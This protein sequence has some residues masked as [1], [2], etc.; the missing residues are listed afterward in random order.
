MAQT[1][2]P[3]RESTVV[4]KERATFKALLAKN[5]N[6]FG[7]LEQVAWKPV[8][9]IVAD[10]GHEQLTCVG[11]NPR[12]SFLEATIAVKRPTG[13]A[14]DLCHA[15]STEYVRFFLDYGSGWEDAGLTGVQVH[16]IPNHP[17]CA[18]RPDKP[19]TYVASL[20]IDPRRDCC[21]HPVLPRVRAI[22]SWQWVPPAG[23]ANVNWK[24]VWG[25]VLDCDVQIAPGPWTIHCLFDQVHVKVP[26]IFEQVQEQPIPLPDPP[27][28]ELAELAELYAPEKQA[29]SAAGSAKLAVAPHRYGLSALHP[30][31]APEGGFD[32]TLLSSSAASFEAIDV[33]LEQAL[34][35]LEKTN[36]D[37][38]YEQLECVGLDETM[39]ERLVATFRIKR[40]TG[41]SGSLCR[42]GSR[43]YVAFWA[44]WDDKCEWTYLGTTQVNVH[45]LEHQIP[46]EGLC[47]SAIL[48]VDLTHRRRGCKEPKIGRV[49]AV[50]SWQVPP[51]TTDP[52]KLEYWGN[53]LDAHVQI[54]P[55]DEIPPGKVLAKIRNLGGIAVEDVAT[56]GNGLTLAADIRFAHFP[57]KTAD[58]WSLQRQCPFGGTVEIEGNFFP[59][60]WY[61][62]KVRRA[63]DPPTSFTALGNSF[64]LE[65]AWSPGY[66]T[67]TSVGG[68]F[69]YADPLMYFTRTLAEW[70]TSEDGLW[71]VQLDIATAPSEASI[72][73]SSKWYSILIDNTGPVGPPALLPTMDIHIA[74]GG[75]CKD[76]DEGATIEGTFIA[77]DAHFGHWA[78]STEPNTAATPSNPPQ[79]SPF[80][81]GT[82]PAPWPAGHGWALNTASPVK[83]KPCGYV[84]R[85]DVSDR[86]IV[87]SHPDLHNSNAIEVGLCLRAK[88]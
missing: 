68:F 71:E 23:A 14:G 79:P 84:V 56:S 55:G 30:L 37:V 31:L 9:K 88:A 6:Y 45:D 16:D 67:Q 26:P 32:E 40:P 49:R 27:P 75:D 11:L 77:D 58:G 5:P 50:L 52:D 78:L 76:F 19:L 1:R 44:D 28:L 48:P 38:E 53:R 34:A 70:S 36:A 64:L 87:N 33:E 35:A 25:N 47:Y 43:E 65:R 81:A 51:S 57:G 42:A 80:L 82:T 54:A 66:D 59:G 41:Y 60:Y 4:L 18:G 85:L 69:K 22:L 74:A 61:R 12:T 62:V 7:N 72:V 24:P 2:K 73:A 39:P 29:K 63:T 17:D 10:T 13:Y 15:G 21:T 46:P 20:R 3:P 83:M 86:S 8:K